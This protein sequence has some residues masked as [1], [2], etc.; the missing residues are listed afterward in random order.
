MALFKSSLGK[1]YALYLVT[2]QEKSIRRE[3]LF[4]DKDCCEEW[5]CAE[6]TGKGV[7]AATEGAIRGFELGVGAGVT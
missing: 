5:G 6:G 3:E 4:E 1:K 7:A 2:V